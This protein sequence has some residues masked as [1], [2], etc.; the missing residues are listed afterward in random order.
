M[1]TFGGKFGT[2]SCGRRSDYLRHRSISCL[3]L[4]DLFGRPKRSEPRCVARVLIR[5]KA[6]TTEFHT[7]VACAV[8]FDGRAGFEPA[9]PQRACDSLQRGVVT[10]RFS[11]MELRMFRFL[12]VNNARI[13]RRY[14]RVVGGRASVHRDRNNSCSHRAASNCFDTSECATLQL[15]RRADARSAQSSGLRALWA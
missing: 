10:V 6:S 1:L 12:R 8:E 7:V 15:V 14:E 2:E 4:T 13:A 9:F 3:P 11:V 5:S